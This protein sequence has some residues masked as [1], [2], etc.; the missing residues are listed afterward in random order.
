MAGRHDPD[1]SDVPEWIVSAAKSLGMNEIKVRWR[2]IR[3]QRAWRGMFEGSEAPAQRRFEH[4]ICANCGAVQDRGAKVC[5]SCNDKLSGA[6]ARLLKKLGLR[7]PEALSV[8]TLLAVCFVFI[9]VRMYIS[10]PGQT[11]WGWKNDTFLTFGGMV[12]RL[13]IQK[14][15]WWRL[16]TACFLH[17]GIFHLGFNT[18]AIMQIGPSVEE[19]FGRGRMLFFFMLTG[20]LAFGVSALASPGSPTAGASGAIMGLIGVAAGWGH[21]DGTSAGREVR[22]QM[23]QWGVYTMFFGIM[24]NANHWAHAA[25]FVFGGLLGYAFDPRQLRRSRG[26]TLSMVL[27]GVGALAMAGTVAIIVFPLGQL[28]QG[29]LAEAE[30][31]I[32][33]DADPKEMFDLENPEKVGA[34]ARSMSAACRLHREGKD[35]EAVKRFLETIA[36]EEAPQVPEGALAPYLTYACQWTEQSRDTCS[37]YRREG[38]EMFG[39]TSEAMTLQLVRRMDALCDNLEPLR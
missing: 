19:L 25:G 18:V 32:Y 13:V 17:L 2:L 16:A 33:E 28:R 11:L 34:T 14:H 29:G 30:A 22:N 4:Q 24:L 36:P 23:V 27:G 26:S 20:V 15:E 35:D 38:A 3:W 1:E 6:P 9:Y 5:S 31:A 7:I 21:R 12:P 37:Q 39:D 10:A 8:S